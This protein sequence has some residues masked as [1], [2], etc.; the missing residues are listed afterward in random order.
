MDM[1]RRS[2]AMQSTKCPRCG[3]VVTITMKNQ[4]YKCFEKRM[5]EYQKTF[6]VSEK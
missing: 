4:K 2:T 3:T 5:S 6:F 1:D